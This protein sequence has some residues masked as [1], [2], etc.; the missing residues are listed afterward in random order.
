MGD[1]TND[2]MWHG[3]ESQTI[4]ADGQCNPGYTGGYDV[5]M[6]ERRTGEF[7]IDINA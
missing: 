7:R 5:Q 1:A 4:N 6:Q 3:L 2:P